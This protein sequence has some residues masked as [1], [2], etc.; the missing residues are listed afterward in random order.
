VKVVSIIQF[1][2]DV[3]LNPKNHILGLISFGHTH[4]GINLLDE[5]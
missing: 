3:W 4:N 1:T 5:L 2:K